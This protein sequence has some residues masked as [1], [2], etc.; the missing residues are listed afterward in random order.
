MTRDEKMAK[1]IEEALG[2]PNV[3]TQFY[4]LKQ[5]AKY[6]WKYFC[7]LDGGN[8][9]QTFDAKITIDQLADVFAQVNEGSRRVLDEQ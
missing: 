5:A 1:L 6:L 7:S 4:E 3:P 2:A 8:Y 9:R